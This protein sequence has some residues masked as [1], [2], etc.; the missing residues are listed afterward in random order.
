[1]AGRSLSGSSFMPVDFLLR[2][3]EITC[4]QNKDVEDDAE[5]LNQYNRNLLRDFREPPSIFEEDQHR[6]DNH[7]R[8]KLSLRHNMDRS[9]GVMP[10]LP[11]GTFLDQVFLSDQG[12][13]DMPDLQGLRNQIS[14][15]VNEVPLYTDEDYSVPS[16]EVSATDHIRNRDKLYGQVSKRL[17]IF[18]TSRDYLPLGNPIGKALHGSSQLKKQLTDQNQGAISEEASGNRNWQVELSNTLPVGWQTTPDNTFKVSKYDTP[19][20]MA[21]QSVDSYRNRIAGR[22]DTD[23]LV[24]FE[25]KNIPRSLALTIMEIMRQ[26]RRLMN[27]AQNNETQYGESNIDTNRKIKQLDSKMME[28][29]R[30]YSETSAVDSANQLLKSERKNVSGIRYIQ[31]DDPNKKYK[32]L[33]GLQLAEMLKHASNNR[34]LGRQD[35]D[36]LRDK[37]VQTATSDAIFNT[38]SNPTLAQNDNTNEMLWQSLAEHRRD[39]QMSVFNYAGIKPG[40]RGQMAGSHDMFNVTEYDRLKHPEINNKRITNN[41][42]LYMPNVLEYEA[43]SELHVPMHNI[44]SVS[45]GNRGIGMTIRDNSYNDMSDLSSIMH[46]QP[47]RIYSQK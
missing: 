3:M 16:K 8:E 31:K 35:T 36:D 11:D 46:S 4:V 20:K 22:L 41:S 30:R 33:V 12:N 14:M 45:T 44:T 32:S 39:E 25:G 5:M 38:A 40:K 1:M 34:K 37:I 21:D 42:N 43:M 15:R 17:Q 2:K 10:Y 6:Y 18:D 7:S 19:R 29:M 9:E 47:G 23:F 24:S 28:L 26:K 27:L 13:S